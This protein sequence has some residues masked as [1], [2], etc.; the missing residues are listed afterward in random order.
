MSDLSFS[1][2]ECEKCGAVWLNGQH[3][4]RTGAKTN[5]SELD[6]ASL[7]CNPYGDSR[8]INPCKGRDGGDTWE[9]RY[10]F[11]MSKTEDLDYDS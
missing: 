10:D 3:I 4:W 11:I 5:N 6:L 7:V 8:C 2:E 9:A 1:R